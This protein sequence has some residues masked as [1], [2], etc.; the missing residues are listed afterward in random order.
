MNNS[1]MEKLVDTVDEDTGVDKMPENTEVDEKTETDEASK[2]YSKKQ[3]R[4][5]KKYKK[6]KASKAVMVTSIVLCALCSVGIVTM[7][8]MNNKTA[9]VDMIKQSDGIK[10]LASN[11]TDSSDMLAIGAGA[12][13]DT[14]GYGFVI[15]A[16]L[17]NRPDVVRLSNNDYYI[18]IMYT[19]GNESVYEEI[20]GLLGTEVGT[21]KEYKKLK[22]VK[23]ENIKSAFEYMGDTAY[24]KESDYDVHV[25][26]SKNY[27]SVIVDTKNSISDKELNKL[28][29][30][31]NKYMNGEI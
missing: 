29:Y 20:L 9:I 27:V 16:D 4:D 11:E 17:D 2:I 5:K 25:V 30:K 23:V 12:I 13:F 22:E 31:I 14:S 10:L 19:G 8:I 28:C 1:E 26:K 18:D 3:K 6:E 7:G 21:D 15:S 24:A